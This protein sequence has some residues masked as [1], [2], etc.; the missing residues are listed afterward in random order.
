M[1]TDDEFYEVAP[2]QRRVNKDYVSLSTNTIYHST[3]DL[4]MEL[5]NLNSTGD[6]SQNGD[7][8]TK[9]VTY[10]MWRDRV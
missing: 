7:R 6:Q 2:L 9:V 5:E 4:G 8:Q 3:T 1:D 10:S